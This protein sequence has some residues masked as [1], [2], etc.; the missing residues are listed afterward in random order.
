MFSPFGGVEKVDVVTNSANGQPRGY[1]LV[2]MSTGTAEM[3]IA[4]L[5]GSKLKGRLITVREALP[6]AGSADA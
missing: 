6:K 4:Q 3:A 5:H 1:A 2:D